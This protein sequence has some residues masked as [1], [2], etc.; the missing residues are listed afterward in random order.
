[1][2][3]FSRKEDYAVI[4]ITTLASY[5]NKRLVSLSEIA[6]TYN[7]SLLFLRNVANELKHQNI[8]IGLEGK[9]GGYKL[10]ENPK[11]LKMGEILRVFSTEPLLECCASFSTTHKKGTCPKEGFCRAGFIW[12]RLNKEFLDKISGLSIYEF[13]NYK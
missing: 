4:L 7:I 1:M 12:R 6:K 8:I 2:V 3:R 11:D 13:M 9:S 5:Y 10:K